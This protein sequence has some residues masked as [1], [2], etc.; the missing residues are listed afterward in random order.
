M[1]KPIWTLL[2]VCCLV[3]PDARAR[4]ELVLP[5]PAAF[6]LFSAATY[7]DNGSRLGDAQFEIKRL[8]D[9]R[10]RMTMIAGIDSG[11]SNHA[12]IVLAPLG[13]ARGLRALEQRSESHDASGQSLGVLHVDHER[14]VARCIP[15]DRN[16]PT[17]SIQLPDQERIANVALNLLFSPMALGKA[18]ATDF[19]IFLCRGGP[20]VVAFS[21]ALAPRVD[22]HPTDRIV[23]IHY[24]PNLA[25]T[26]RWLAGDWLP[27]YSFWLD[28]QGDYLAHRISLYAAGPEVLV[29]RDG[30]SPRTLTPEP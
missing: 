6:G 15:P 17:Q 7:D 24:E 10:V 21:A 25:R 11:A 1:Q 8:E 19:Q 27:Q 16:E 9:G 3:A 28:G 2:L 12:S 23:E 26:I 4:S 20:R 18:H 22:A 14:G 30:I 29:V 13:Q 5:Y